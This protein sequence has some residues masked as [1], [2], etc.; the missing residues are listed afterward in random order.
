MRRSIVLLQLSSMPKQR[1][2]LMHVREH[3]GK[4]ATE[5]RKGNAKRKSTTKRP[6]NTSSM[7]VKCYFLE[8]SSLDS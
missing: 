1:G 8:K 2:T 3:T 4:G 5:Q 6:K 7:I